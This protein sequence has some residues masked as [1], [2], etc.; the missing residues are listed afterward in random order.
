MLENPDGGA[1]W[2]GKMPA[3]GDFVSRRLPA[4]WVA[5]WDDWLQQQLPR[6]RAAHGDDAWLALYLVAPVRRFWLAPGLL[7]PAAWLGVLMPSVDSVGRHFPFTL[8]VALPPPSDALADALAGDVWFAAADALARQ[9][10]DPA[11]D[12]SALERAVSALPLLPGA[13]RVEPRAGLAQRL[14]QACPGARS[15]WWCEGAADV[16]DFVLAPAMPAGAA[17]DALL[18]NPPASA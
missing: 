12:V 7:A 9:A 14:A 3:H 17:F 6:S 13:R 15:V 11:F 4:D 2:F 16:A 1:G 10:L 8:A 5:A 18:H